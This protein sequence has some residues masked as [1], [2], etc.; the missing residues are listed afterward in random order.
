MVTIA[1]SKNSDLSVAIDLT[2]EWDK[3]FEDGSLMQGCIVARTEFINENPKV[4]AKFLEEYKSS[5][6]Y[7]NES[8]ESAAALIAEMGIFENANVAKAAI[9][10]CNIKYIDGKAMADAL[11]VFFGA[12]HSINP[13]AVGG[14]VPDSG[15]YYNGNS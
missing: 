13:A 2:S 6:N 8:T 11:S 1:K 15:I 14:A 4:V 10:K 9:P 12:L 3:H 5:V 7:V